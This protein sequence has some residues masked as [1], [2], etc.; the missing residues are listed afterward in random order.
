MRLEHFYH[1]GDDVMIHVPKQFRSKKKHVTDGPFP[2][3][4]AYN[5][6][7]VTVD[8]GSTQQQAGS[9]RIFPC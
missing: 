7:T 1:P 6:G 8:K 9:H 2:I 3:C 5:N 4:A